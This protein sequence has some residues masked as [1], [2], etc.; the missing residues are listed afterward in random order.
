[1]TVNRDQGAREVAA[2]DASRAGAVLLAAGE[3][4][5]MGGINKLLIEV[6]GVPMVRRMAAAIR[7]AGIG[8]I[9]LVLG[10][11][12]DRIE[13]LVRDLGVT[14]VRHD[15]YAEGQQGSVLAGLRALS[16]AADPVM[17]VLGDLPLL[18]PVDIIALLAAFA[19]RPPG[20]RVLLPWHQGR[21]GNPVVVD[22]WVVDRVRAEQDAADGL[23]G[24][25]DAH[26]DIVASFDAPSDHYVFDLDTPADIER[27]ERRIGRP[28]RAGAGSG[29]GD[30]SGPTVSGSQGDQ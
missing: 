7:S 19:A 2:I 3:S 29:S 30:G 12:A 8:E 22:R 20:S 21:R 16:A 1:M 9:V 18:E 23:R 26:R 6:D 4:R 13:P 25:I 5:R 28:V 15:G 11:Q 17:V 27:L 10:H 24:F 14:L